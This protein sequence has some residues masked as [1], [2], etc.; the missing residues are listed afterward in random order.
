MKK[1]EYIFKN[2]LLKLL[3]LFSSFRSRSGSKKEF[4]RVLFIRLNKI[5]DALVTTPLIQEVKSR[6]NCM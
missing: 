3:I 1:L 5:G 4:K 2:L 6:F